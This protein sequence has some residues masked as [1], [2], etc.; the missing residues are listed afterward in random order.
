MMVDFLIIGAQKAGSTWLSETLRS[1]PGVSV[2]K[3]EIHFFSTDENY[4]KGRRWY[5]SR[6]QQRPAPVLYGEKTPEYLTVIPTANRRT[7]TETSYRI[8]SYNKEMRLLAVLREPV[9]RLRSAINHMYRTRRIAPWISAHDLLLG[10]HR[11]SGEEFSLLQNGQYYE[12]LA[13]YY[14]LFPKCQ[15][16]VLFFE[17]DIVEKPNETLADVCSF[18][19]IEFRSSYFPTLTVKKNEYQMSLPAMTLNYLFPALRPLSNRLNHFFPAYRVRMDAETTAFLRQFYQPSNER[20]A[21]LIGRLPDS[22]VYA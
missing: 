2:P 5:H 10:D 8:L 21:Q 14:R 20:L 15:I 16:K 6:F 18:L 3:E 13:E 17:R 19:G 11:A 12:N 22:W 7:S 4:E 9:S 1:H